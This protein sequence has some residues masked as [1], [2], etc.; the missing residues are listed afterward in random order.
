MIKLPYNEP[1]AAHILSFMAVLD[2]YSVLKS[3]LVN[4]EKQAIARDLALGTPQEFSLMTV[5]EKQ[6]LGLYRRVQ[7][8]MRR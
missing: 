7:I 2:P 1:R 4:D 5:K 8:F 6:V 3:L